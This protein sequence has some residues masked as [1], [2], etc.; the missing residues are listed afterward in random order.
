MDDSQS[1]ADLHPPDLD[2]LILRLADRQTA[3]S[4]YIDRRWSDLD[5]LHLT[6]LLSIHGQN[7]AR[8]GRLLRDWRAVHGD[9]PDPL[10]EAIDEALAELSVEWGV[11][12]TGSDPLG[13]NAP[14]HPPIDIDDLIEDLDEKCA[15]LARLLDRCQGEG[16]DDR[17]VRLSALHSRNAAHLGGLFRVRRALYPRAPEEMEALIA[18]VIDSPYWEDDDGDVE[19]PDAPQP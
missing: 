7:A 4:R 2:D 8:L 14:S 19:A 15:R 16:D 17:M 13:A 12:L 3:L 10:D 1:A 18:S 9:P 11:D 5:E 6:R